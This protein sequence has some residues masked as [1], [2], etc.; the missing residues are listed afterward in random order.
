LANTPRGGDARAN[1]SQHGG[2]G[3]ISTLLIV[4]VILMVLGRI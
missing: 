3:I 2:V 4:I 1:S